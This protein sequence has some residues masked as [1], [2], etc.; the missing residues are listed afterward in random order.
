M[1]NNLKQLTLM[2]LMFVG[3][4][5]FLYAKDNNQTSLFSPSSNIAWDA[6]QL[7][8][9]K[10]GDAK[11]GE[12][13]NKEK[14]CSLCH[15]DKGISNS[16]NWP[17]L[18]GQL[19]NYTFKQMRDYKDKNREDSNPSSMMSMLAN[20]L[21]DK[22]IAD[23]AIYYSSLP[24]PVKR[25][26]ELSLNNQIKKIIPLIK[27]GDGSRMIPPC[28]SCHGAKAQGT[29]MDIPL[30]AAQKAIYFK[31]TMHEF[32]NAVRHNDIYS[33][34]RII[35]KSLTDD[36]IDSLTE[37]FATAYTHDRSDQEK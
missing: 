29:L 22:E 2:S 31:K 33:R 37:Y 10:S 11:K 5:S 1:M 25:E 6:A 12:A 9:V 15:G 23:L 36:E 21:T 30:I 4:I 26:K 16:R 7:N 8:F 28:L 17:N 32:K 19:A 18:A 35:A 3:S 14:M 24:I 27:R 13:L 20:Q 34:M